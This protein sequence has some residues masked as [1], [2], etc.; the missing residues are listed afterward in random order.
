MTTTLIPTTSPVSTT[1]RSTRTSRAW[2]WSGI[3]AGVAALA[4]VVVSGVLTVERGL[5]VDNARVAEALDGK[6]PAVWIFQVLTTAI[7]IAALVF[8]AGLRRRLSDQEPA[9]SLVPALAAGGLVTVAVM[10]LVGGGISTEM[11]HTLRNVDESDPDT[12]AAQLAIF[13]TMSWVWAGIGL[14]AAAVGFGALRNGSAARWIGRLSIGTAVL[15]GLTQIVPFQY[16]A[17]LPGALWLIVAGAGF[18][19]EARVQ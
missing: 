12:L 15:I 2:A 8:A 7:A 13:N 4:S 3:V 1:A 9:G 5:L 11:F 17:M 14:T 16:L 19:R 10:S 18:V 6:A